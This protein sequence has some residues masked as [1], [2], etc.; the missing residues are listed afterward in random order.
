MIK[1]FYYWLW[2]D[3]CKCSAPFTI[4]MRQSAKA[5]PLPWILIPLVFLNAFWLLICHL[6]GLW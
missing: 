1:R 6:W 5:H 2:H 3:L 4:I